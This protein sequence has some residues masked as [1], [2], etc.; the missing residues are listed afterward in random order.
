MKGGLPQPPPH[1]PAGACAEIIMRRLILSIL[2]LCLILSSCAVPQPSPSES[3]ILPRNLPETPSASDRSPTPLKDGYDLMPEESPLEEG[4]A[5]N[6]AYI[7]AIPS[8]PSVEPE[9]S[10]T[11]S[12]A[13]ASESIAPDEST[14]VDGELEE[15]VVPF[16]VGNSLVEGLRLNSDDGYPFYCEVGISLPTL[17]R[18]LAL[19]DDY[20]IAIIEMG[21]NELGA[22]SEESFKNSYQELIEILD[23]PCY[24]L[25]IP[26]I[27]WAKS[28]YAARVN[29]TNVRLYNDYIRSVCSETFVDCSAF[30][31]DTLP[32]EWTRDGLHLTSSTYANWYQWIIKKVGLDQ[33]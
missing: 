7:T 8:T 23:C 6:A 27:N 28:R 30:F 15:G 19:P 31:G 1:F 5:R 25:S 14:E 29:N 20:D 12:P 13:G 4:M 33:Y 10:A 17:N 26:P 16:F 21:S 11:A 3:Q 18:K 24:C 32:A 22:Y 2:T 9:D